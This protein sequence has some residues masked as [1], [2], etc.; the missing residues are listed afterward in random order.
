M[1]RRNRDVDDLE[2][3]N[4]SMSATGLDVDGGHRFYRNELGIEFHLTLTFQDKINLRHFA[5]IMSSGVLL[6]VDHVEAGRVLFGVSKG[7][8]SNTAWTRDRRDFVELGNEVI[9]HT[10]DARLKMRWVQPADSPRAVA[11]S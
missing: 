9:W 2:V 5:V 6:D 1:K 10:S 7:A 4:G 11:D 8:A 3:P